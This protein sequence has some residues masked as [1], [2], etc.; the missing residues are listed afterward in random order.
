MQLLGIG[1]K[2]IAVAAEFAEKVALARVQFKNATL[3]QLDLDWH[4]TKWLTFL[5][6]AETKS[7]LNANPKRNYIMKS[8]V[9]FCLNGK[10]GQALDAYLMK[11]TMKKWQSKFNLAISNSQQT[12]VM[13][14][15]RVLRLYFKNCGI[16]A[17][18]LVQLSCFMSINGLL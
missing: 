17:M 12:S 4:E 1:M 8:I 18:C 7:A 9:E 16:Q 14:R 6:N 2:D 15:I 13:I 3:S 5:P 11:L 10:A